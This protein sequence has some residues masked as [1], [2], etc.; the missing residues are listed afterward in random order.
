M[1]DVLDGPVKTKKTGG[2]FVFIK[3]GIHIKNMSITARHLHLT[4]MVISYIR[5]EVFLEMRLN[6]VDIEI[7]I[8]QLQS[9]KT[10]W[11]K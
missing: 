11:L 1:R 10:V 7:H 6:S 5:A 3:T 4:K 2:F 9:G 8:F